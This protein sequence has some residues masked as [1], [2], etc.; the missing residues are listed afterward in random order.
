MIEKY[1]RFGHDSATLSPGL[2]PRDTSRLATWL[3]APF[4]CAYVKRLSPNTM[5][6]RSAY[7]AAEFSKRDARLPTTSPRLAGDFQ[8]YPHGFAVVQGGRQNR[9]PVSCSYACT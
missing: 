7:L 9:S 5:A 8:P 4:T 3:A 6:V 1:G 2:M